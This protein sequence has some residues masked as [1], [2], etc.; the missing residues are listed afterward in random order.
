MTARMSSR[1]AAS[2]AA[3]LGVALVCVAATVGGVS[4]ATDDRIRVTPLAR[5]GQ[6]YVSFEVLDAFADDT[7]D[8]M[9][10]GLLTTFLYD[11][12]LRRPTLLWFDR[13]VASAQV[14]AR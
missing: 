4:G 3:W 1:R 11:V 2:P 5:D 7:R 9:Q 14:T 12:E 13:L 6:V 10:S 8:A